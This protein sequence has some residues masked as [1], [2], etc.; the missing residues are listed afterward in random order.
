MLLPGLRAVQ[1]AAKDMVQVHTHT[2]YLPRPTPLSP[3]DC[4][5]TSYAPFATFLRSPYAR[6]ATSLRAWHGVRGTE[7]GG[8]GQAVNEGKREREVVQQYE[9]IVSQVLLPSRDSRSSLHVSFVSLHVIAPAVRARRQP[10]G[11][12]LS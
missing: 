8:A 9:R 6:S 7:V 10:G 3:Y 12:A 11:S 2:H 5:T 1:Q 4:S